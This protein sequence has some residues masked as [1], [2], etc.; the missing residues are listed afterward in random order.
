MSEDVKKGGNVIV[1]PKFKV[2]FPYVFRPQKSLQEGG[3]PKFSVVMLFEAG[4]DLGLLKNAAA[5]AVVAKWG[6]DKVKWP[7]N[8]RTPFRD[9][10]EKKYEGYVPGS[11]FVTATSKQKPGLVDI[12]VQP[13]IDEAQFYAG[14]WAIAAIRA[15]TYDKAGNNGVSFGLQHIQKQA[16]GDPLGGRTKPEEHF[17]PV[18]GAEGAAAGAAATDLFG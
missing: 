17:E 11:I 15:F 1:T 3:E 14:C 6:P 4:A 2:S 5:E 16:D 12:T 9:Q 18:K 7:G 13:I 10:G 8:L